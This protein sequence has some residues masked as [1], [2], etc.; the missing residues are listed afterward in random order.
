VRGYLESEALG[1]SALRAALEL[2]GPS[3]AAGHFSDLHLL[4]FVDGATLR[5]QEALPGQENSYTL[6]AA[7]VGVRAR[8][9]RFLL[10]ALD[11]A[12]PLRDGTTTEQG[13]TRLHFRLTSEF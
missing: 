2:H 7:G 9:N 11:L 10:G 12:Q 3:F 6:A 13:D 5:V 8:M 1:D 4:A